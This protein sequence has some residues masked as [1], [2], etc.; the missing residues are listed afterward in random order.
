MQLFVETIW[1][2]TRIIGIVAVA[3]IVVVTQFG[4]VAFEV[5]LKADILQ[6]GLNYQNT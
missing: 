5:P 6:S 4:R 2:V 1:G 3:L